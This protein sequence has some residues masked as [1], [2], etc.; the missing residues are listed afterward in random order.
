ML[1]V[2]QSHG[3]QFHHYLR[4]WYDIGPETRALAR[5]GPLP[6]TPGEI[7]DDAQRHL[8]ILSMPAKYALDELGNAAED[9]GA[10]GQVEQH[11]EGIDIGAMVDR[12]A[13]RHRL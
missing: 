10:R 13:L 12:D 3:R 1:V 2:E 5:P 4:A 9:Q 11:A 7:V 6:I 8:H